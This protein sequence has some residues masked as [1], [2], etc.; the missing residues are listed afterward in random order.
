M[1]THLC[2]VV[3]VR[4]V[5]SD[6]FQTAAE[7]FDMAVGDLKEE[8]RLRTLGKTT[9]KDVSLDVIEIELRHA[10]FC[11]MCWRNGMVSAQS[12]QTG[13]S[14]KYHLEHVWSAAVYRNVQSSSRV[15]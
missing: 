3:S 11:E 15:Y 12:D 7:V 6:L 2:R 1:P 5:F 8:E 9:E 13:S 4:D 10:E 14:L